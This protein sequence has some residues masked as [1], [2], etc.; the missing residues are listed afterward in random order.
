MDLS[1]L[2]HCLENP[3]G[4]AKAILFSQTMTKAENQRQITIQEQQWIGAGKLCQGSLSKQVG[5][6]TTAIRGK[7]TRPRSREPGRT[8]ESQGQQVKTSLGEGSV[9]KIREM[10]GFDMQLVMNSMGR[11]EKLISVC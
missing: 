3:K 8:K 2:L 10:V 11:V 5:P 6:G 1:G 4:L 7:S 9:K